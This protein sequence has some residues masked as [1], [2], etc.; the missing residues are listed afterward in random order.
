MR[1]LMIWVAVAAA[2]LIPVVLAAGSPYLASRNAAY[3]VASFAGV[4]SLSLLLFQPLLA[5]GY[6]PGLNLPRARRAH[7]VVGSGLFVV[8][9]L[10]IGGLY[11]TSPPDTL[12]ALLLVSPTP[13]S[14]YGVIALWSLLLTGVL[15]AYRRLL[16]AATWRVLHNALGL[17]V[18][19]STVV[20]AL[21]IEGTMEPISKVAVCTALLLVTGVAL[22]DLRLLRRGR[23]QR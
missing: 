14:V 10:H 6:L 16:R 22:V 21:Q 20:H 2:A 8:A 7:R 5:A 17:V 18:G 11:L 1:G 3:I 13:F 12:D 23:L 9:A 19:I 4:A 15:V